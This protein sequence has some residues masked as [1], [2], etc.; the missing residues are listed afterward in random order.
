MPFDIFIVIENEKTCK[1]EL[2]T[3]FFGTEEVTGL[4]PEQAVKVKQMLQLQLRAGRMEM[5]EE[6]NSSIRKIE[7]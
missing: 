5:R 1:V 3:D 2:I 6:I 4:S 7:S